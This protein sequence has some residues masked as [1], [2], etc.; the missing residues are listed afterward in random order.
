M[1][2]AL[3]KSDIPED[4]CGWLAS[5]KLD[6]IRCIFQSGKFLTR[7]GH[8]LKAPAWFVKGMPDMRLDGELYMGRGTF[9]K[10][11]SVLQRKDSDWEGVQFHVFD[12]ADVGTIEERIE[13]LDA[14]K[15][16][17]H[18]VRVLHFPLS[19]HD[20]LDR[21]EKAVVAAGGEGMV[22]RRPGS[23]YRPGRIGDVVKVKRITAD[24]DRWQG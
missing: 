16:P 9:D 20:E 17:K 22:I 2:F 1:S 21:M 14:A 19:G 5:E 23:Q 7:N 12:L 4:V 6:G 8:A 15:L 24:T 10:L 18:V 13:A 11:Q 3:L